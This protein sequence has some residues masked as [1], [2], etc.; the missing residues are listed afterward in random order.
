MFFMANVKNST[1]IQVFTVTFRSVL[2]RVL[3]YLV[4]HKF[5]V[6][7]INWLI[8]GQFRCPRYCLHLCHNPFL[9][10]FTGH[11]SF[12]WDHCGQLYLCLVEAYVSHIPWD[13]PLV[14]L[15]VS[16]ADKPISSRYL[17]AGIGEARNQELCYHLRFCLH[18]CHYHH[19][20]QS[21]SSCQW[22]QNIWI[23]S[24]SQ[25]VCLTESETKTMHAH[26]P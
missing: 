3:W 6:M 9:L 22:L 4:N 24:V 21:S 8:K 13:S 19:H 2:Y 11:K 5:R 17:R 20:C 14:F 1:V 7:T 18:L 12:V 26:G 23:N 16:M 25:M 15:T 10:I